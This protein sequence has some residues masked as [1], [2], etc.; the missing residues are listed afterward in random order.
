MNSARALTQLL[1]KVLLF[2]ECI[3]AIY[4]NRPIRVSLRI[5][6]I[7]CRFFFK[8]FFLF[9]FFNIVTWSQQTVCRI[10]RNYW[11]MICFFPINK[12][13][14]RTHTHMS[15]IHIQRQVS[16]NCRTS[17]LYLL[18]HF[19]K[20]NI[21]STQMTSS[22]LFSCQQPS[23]ISQKIEGLVSA[24]YFRSNWEEQRSAGLRIMKTKYLQEKYDSSS[25]IQRFCHS[26]STR[27]TNSLTYWNYCDLF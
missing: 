2:Y 8:Y 27:S 5:V 9:L 14:S 23:T 6:M 19:W 22:R 25:K 10:W 18:P 12:S 7:M 15:I 4:R 13:S 16:V 20:R 24:Q 11:C 21:H 3:F 1:I 17:L 26:A